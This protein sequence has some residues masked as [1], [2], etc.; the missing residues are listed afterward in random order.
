MPLL[1]SLRH[2]ILGGSL[3][4]P[5]DPSSLGC[6]NSRPLSSSLTLLVYSSLKPGSDYRYIY[7]H[8]TLDHWRLDS[9]GFPGNPPDLSSSGIIAVF[10]CS[11]CR[12]RG[13][14]YS[15][16]KPA[17]DYRYISTP[18]AIILCVI[19]GV[20]ILGGLLETLRIYQ[21]LGSSTWSAVLLVAIGVWCLLSGCC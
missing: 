1:L 2:L 10:C 4:D 11:T 8:P 15:S 3:G 16:T 7:Y 9:G 13:L 12:Y 17:S 21:A 19:T 18:S 5:P 6:E 20:L 14:V